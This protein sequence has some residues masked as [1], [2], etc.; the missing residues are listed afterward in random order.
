MGS[1]QRLMYSRVQKS[2]EKGKKSLSPT[3]TTSVV[4]PTK[5]G[6]YAQQVEAI[7]N[8]Y[9]DFN[10][11]YQFKASEHNERLQMSREDQKTT[12]LGPSCY[13]PDKNP[14]LY[15]APEWTIRGR[16][17]DTTE[18]NDGP[19]PGSYDD[20]TLSFGANLNECTIGVRREE[21]IYECPGPGEY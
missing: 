6:E 16:Y 3:K 11:T 19:A 8:M 13:S 15:K 2:S 10:S 17:P 21:K 14:V 7:R 18:L 9:K 5:G 20:K 1:Y 4:S 12:N